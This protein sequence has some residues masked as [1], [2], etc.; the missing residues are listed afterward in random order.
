MVV[1]ATA[2]QRELQ[3]LQEERA[4][5]LALSRSAQLEARRVQRECDTLKDKLNAAELLSHKQSM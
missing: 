5:E 2:L 3:K 1:D 4:I